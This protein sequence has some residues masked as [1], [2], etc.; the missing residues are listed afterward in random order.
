MSRVA[1]IGIGAAAPEQALAQPDAT[2]VAVAF[3]PDPDA[4]RVIRALYRRTGVRTRG[5]VLADGHGRLEG[6]E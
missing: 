6:D 4:A 2:D 1:L 5:S 3:S